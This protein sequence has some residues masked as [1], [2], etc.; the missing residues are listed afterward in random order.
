MHFCSWGWVE[1]A[2]IPGGELRK[3]SGVEDGRQV[4]EALV[5]PEA[6]HGEEQG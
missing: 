3:R 4:Q 6:D 2:A 5:A 1:G